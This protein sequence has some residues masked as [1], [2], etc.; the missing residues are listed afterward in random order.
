MNKVTT[1]FAVIALGA[2][3]IT[4][5]I[6][7]K[8]NNLEVE[9]SDLQKQIAVMKTQKP[10]TITVT[11]TKVIT[12]Y[13]DGKTIVKERVPEGYVRFDIAKYEQLQDDMA[14]LELEIATVKGDLESAEADTT[15]KAERIDVLKKRLGD[16]TRAWTDLY[17]KINTP[18]FVTVVNRGWCLRPQIGVGYSGKF[19]PYVG[20][21][22]GFYNKVGF[23]VGATSEQVG[24]GITR[25]MFDVVPI[26][27]NT[28][29]IL[30]YGVPFEKGGNRLFM[31]LGVG[32]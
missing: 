13:R 31:G 10:E 15:V 22:Y 19:V 3:L 5:A 24:L 1:L 6:T 21:K 9:V 2:I 20:V 25:K 14:N 16:M 4:T 29:I 26:L 11:E 27:K 28:E 12:K 32:I 7:I 18:S 8:N 30:Q 23:T 17:V